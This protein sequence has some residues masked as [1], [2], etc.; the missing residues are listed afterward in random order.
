MTDRTYPDDFDTAT[1][2]GTQPYP[3]PKD[4]L[5]AVAEGD[6]V[7]WIRYEA[8]ENAAEADHYHEI[9]D[10]V[11]SESP[12]DVAWIWRAGGPDEWHH[13][14]KING[15]SVLELSK[16]DD[17]DAL[18]TVI[19]VALERA[20]SGD[21]VDESLLD[22]L[23]LEHLRLGS[24]ERRSSPPDGQDTL[25]DGGV[26][27]A[28]E[29]REAWLEDADRVR[30][31]V[32][33]ANEAAATAAIQAAGVSGDRNDT[34][35]LRNT[36]KAMLHAYDQSVRALTTL[37]NVIRTSSLEVGVETAKEITTDHGDRMQEQYDEPLSMLAVELLKQNRREWL[38]RKRD[39][40]GH[41]AVTRHGLTANQR[42][43]LNE[44]QAGASPGMVQDTIATLRGEADELR[45]RDDADDHM[46][47]VIEGLEHRAETLE[48]AIDGGGE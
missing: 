35:A 23:G 4:W 6:G 13:E 39:T 36:Y 14:L 8:A 17:T 31:R 38:W 27:A 18:Y 47:D 16:T 11:I 42:S 32:A 15:E 46:E 21:E 2:S 10:D 20:A 48:A 30:S 9:D 22:D 25:P 33:S 45:H 7:K 19:A 3:V 26:P 44:L 43:W 34:M 41:D 40:N 12:D 5:L 29:R 37:E 24:D 28:G 1:Y